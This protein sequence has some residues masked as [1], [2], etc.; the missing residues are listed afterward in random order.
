MSRL[1][2]LTYADRR[3]EGDTKCCNSVHDFGKFLF[4][5]LHLSLRHFKDESIMHR[6]H[7]ATLTP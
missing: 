2:I 5:G 3:N 7:H 6:M 4:H 1:P